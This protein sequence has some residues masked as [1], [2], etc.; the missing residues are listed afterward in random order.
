MAKTSKP[1]PAALGFRVKSGWA[2]AVLLTGPSSAPKPVRCQ[3]VLLSDPN[4]PQSKQPHHA[5]L[6]R[7]GK[8]GKAL[9]EELCCVV[10]DAARK[11][12]QQLLKQAAA[13]GYGVMGA[14][15]VVGS[16][17]DPATLHSEHIRAHGLEGQ[18][19]RTALEDALREQGLPSRVLLEKNAYTTASPVLRKSAPE[20]KRIIAGLGDSHEG[21]WRAEEKLAA[22]AAWIALCA[23]K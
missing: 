7:P 12:V 2:M 19:F 20:T 5:A 3:T 23:H 13:D 14:G 16:L 22:L 9:A 8:E 10:A 11:S 1:T 21:T 4:I 6:D 17:V 18:L 15:L